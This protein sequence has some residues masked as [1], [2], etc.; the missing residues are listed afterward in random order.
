MLAMLDMMGL[1]VMM[2]TRGGLD[3]AI[4]HRGSGL[5]GGERRRIGLA[6]AILSGR[7]FLLL[8]EPTADLDADNAD[9]IRALLTNVARTRTV[10]AAT[11]DAALLAHARSVLEIPV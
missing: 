2:A 11:H 10:I 6:R 9:A 3:M 4:D 7:P 8:D 1:G 5:S